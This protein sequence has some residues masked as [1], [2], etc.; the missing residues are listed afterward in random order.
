MLTE[1]DLQVGRVYR[2][3]RPIGVFVNFATRVPN[4]RV[5]LWMGDGKV[6]YDGPTV[7]VGQRQPKVTVEAFLKWAAYDCTQEMPEGDKWAP[8]PITA[9]QKEACKASVKEAAAEKPVAP[10]Q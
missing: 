6:Q 4:D 9:G 5:I 2:A 8:W 10:I 3:K 1:N 7:K